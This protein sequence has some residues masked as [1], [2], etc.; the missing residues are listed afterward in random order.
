[1]KMTLLLCHL[2]MMAL[3]TW[4]ITELFTADRITSK[5]RQKFPTYLW[6]CPRCM[7]VWAGAWCA[8]MFWAFPWANWPFALAWLYLAHIDWHVGRRIANRGREFTVRITQGPSGQ[9]NQWSVD[10]N[11]L[12]PQELYEVMRMV[13][14]PPSPTPAPPPVAPT[15]PVNGGEHTPQ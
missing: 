9:S 8:L 3:A 11:E 10:K 7:S 2:V 6:Q 15:Q 14:M 12:Q 1:M 4:R 13:T 5:F